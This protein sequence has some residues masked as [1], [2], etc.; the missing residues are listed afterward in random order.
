ME[1]Y[2]AIL[3]Y[4]TGARNSSV[5][6]RTGVSQAASRKAMVPPGFNADFRGP[7]SLPE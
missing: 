6:S 7:S 1:V 5:C 4:W 3:S 2:R